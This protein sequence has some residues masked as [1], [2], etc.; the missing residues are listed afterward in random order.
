[1]QTSTVPD[2]EE[3]TTESQRLERLHPG[4]AV[5]WAAERFGSTLVTTASF[6]NAVLVH[7]V[8]THA[9]GTPIV[10]LDTG[11]LFAE[12]TWFANDL[13]DRF[14]F[15]LTVV[16]PLPGVG[17]DFRSSLDGCCAARKVEPLQRALSGHHAWISGLRRAD[18]PNRAHTPILSYDASR[19]LVK[20]SP[21]A[22]MTDE[23]VELYHELYDLPRHPLR[24]KGYHSI[25][26]WPCTRPVAPG[27]DR[28]AGRW[29]GSSKTECGIHLPA[30]TTLTVRSAPA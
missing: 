29:A 17:V 22:A 9:P 5:K 7:L 18:S 28:R 4:E 21:L 12:T 20:V 11:F 3:L 15:E 25:G 2:L 27:E 8:A 13:R 26:C 10:L 1:M 23:E 6:Q 24:D 30:P 16:S 19:D 14:G